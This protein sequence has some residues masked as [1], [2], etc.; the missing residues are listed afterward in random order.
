MPEQHKVDLWQLTDLCT[1]WCIHVIATLRIAEHITSGKDHIADLAAAAACDQYA[2]HRVLT[3]LVQ[4]GLFEEPAS[5]R[6]VVNDAARSLLDPGMRIGLDLSGIGGRMAGAW[7]TLPAYVRTGKSSYHEVF[8]MSFWEDLNAHPDIGAS[9]DE[10]MGITGHGTPNA[11]FPITAGWD[12]VRT[13][14]DVGG[15]TGAMLAELLRLRPNL[16]GTLVDFPQ[17]VARSAATFSAAGVAD[18]VTTAGQSFFDPLPAGADLYYLRKVIDNWPD[19]EAKAILIRCAEAACPSGR[20]VILGGAVRDNAPRP[21]S[22]DQVLVGGK[23]RTES[24]LR[25]LARSAGLNVIANASAQSGYHV[26]E[27][28]PSA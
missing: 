15:G 16:R 22:I 23:H 20:V 24:E 21:I 8:G 10:L 17:T 25:D 9:F 4:K 6:F 19:T 3:H 7:T 1:P 13:V 2:L 28:R 5:G 27:C 26:T 14:V 12:S 11:D 18:R